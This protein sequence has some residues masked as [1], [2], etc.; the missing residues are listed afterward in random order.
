M[1]TRFHNN[2]IQPKVYTDSTMRYP[3]TRRAFQAELVKPSSQ[4]QPL[5]H[6]KWKEAM[7]SEYQALLR[8][9]T[10]C[11]VPPQKRRNAINSKWVFKLKYKYDG[12][13]VRHKARLV[14]KGF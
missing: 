8:N 7:D 13:I 14:A 9:N 4:I 11:L 12:S 3:L 6:P 5:E 1:Q 2:I 10:G